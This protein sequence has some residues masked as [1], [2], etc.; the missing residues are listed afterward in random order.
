MK[1]KS[2]EKIKNFLADFDKFVEYLYTRDV[3]LEKAT[4]HISMEFLFEM[5][6][7]MSIKQQDVTYKSTQ[8]SY[9][10]FHLFYNLVVESKLFV[11]SKIK[12]DKLVLKHTERL[13]MFKKLNELEKYI[14]L[15]EILWVDCDFK[16]FKFQS[17]CSLN[18]FTVDI[19]LG[20]FL[21]KE[22]NKPIVIDEFTINISTILLYFSYFGV[23]DVVEDVEMKLRYNTSKGFII[24]E[25]ILTPV[26]KK[27][28]N[29]LNKKR[30]LEEWN[31]SHRKEYGEWKI[32][33]EE[34]FFIPFKG[35]FEDVLLE[36]TLPR[37]KIQFKDGIYTFQASL[38]NDTLS[39]I[40]LSAHDT[41]QDL[42]NLIQKAFQFDN[43]H[44]YSF[45]MDGEPWSK[46]EFK[47]P[48]GNGGPNAKEAKI[49][50]LELI[51]KQNFLYIFDY[52][53]AWKFNIEVIKIENED[54][55]EFKSKIIEIKGK[56]PQ[57]YPDYTT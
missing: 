28:I 31:I 49:G 1:F 10:M 21:E 43:D 29:I 46:N 5:N 42:H 6:E 47:S 11:V 51:E 55:K 14:Y 9:P 24:K 3:T 54:N 34:D 39:K 36:K 13:E 27:I 4:D 25:V 17:Y 20:E 33:L 57:Q 22:V 30:N 12:G 8:L 52:A 32:E 38:D 45:F 40:Q 2:N 48:F 16:K 19:K 44:M 37:R 7:M 41:L 56:P 15:L 23:M 53:N 35:I 26:G 18:V 50:E